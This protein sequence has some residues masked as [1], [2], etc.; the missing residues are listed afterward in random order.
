[1]TITMAMSEQ[2][3]RDGRQSILNNSSRYLQWA[4][5]EPTRREFYMAHRKAQQRHLANLRAAARITVLPG[6]IEWARAM[7]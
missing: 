6:S 5:Q 1:M 3:Y 2:T 4:Q 7:R